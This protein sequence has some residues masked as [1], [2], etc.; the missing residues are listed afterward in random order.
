[1]HAAGSNE[2]LQ[3]DWA[4]QSMHSINANAQHRY[5]NPACGSL[6]AQVSQCDA[7]V[8]PSACLRHP[9]M[10]CSY[11]LEPMSSQIKLVR[12]WLGTSLSH[13]STLLHSCSCSVACQVLLHLPTR[14]R[15][16]GFSRG[17]E[18]S[19]CWQVH[20][21]AAPLSCPPASYTPCS[22]SL[23]PAGHYRTTCV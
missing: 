8:H 18:A 13:H 7:S 14:P 4:A 9:C 12:L 21:S 16:H 19:W 2:G 10:L 3:P 20:T 15:V 17:V 1:M 22:C 6:H 11:F 23:T 5:A